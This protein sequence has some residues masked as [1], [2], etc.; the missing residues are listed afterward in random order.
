MIIDCHFHLE[1]RVC[2]VDRLVSDMQR[3]GVDRVALMGSIIGPFREPPVFLIKLLQVCLE[4]SITRGLAKAFITKFTDGERS[5]YSG[6]PT[7]L[8]R[9]R[10]TRRSSARS[11]STLTNSSGGSS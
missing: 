7:C 2:R 9:T 1:E 5:R 8:R 11:D 6:S 3:H 4:N 10:T